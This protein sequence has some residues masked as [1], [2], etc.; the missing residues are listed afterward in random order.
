MSSNPDIY[1]PKSVLAYGS[2]P[3]TKLKSDAL[4]AYQ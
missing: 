1:F 4:H 3:L 2:G